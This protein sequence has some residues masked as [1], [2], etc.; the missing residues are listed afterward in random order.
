M[1]MPGPPAPEPAKSNTKVIRIDVVAVV[2]AVVAGVVFFLNKEAPA[3]SQAGDCIHVVDPNPAA[4]KIEKTE[5]TS[6][7]AQY[8]VGMTRDDPNGKCPSQNYLAYS[9]TGGSSEV[10]LCMVLMAK[11]GDCFKP[12]GAVV[13]VKVDCAQGAEFKVSKVIEGSDD[14]KKCGAGENATNAVAYPEPKLTLCRV[15]PDAPGGGA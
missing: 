4:P 5:C 7:D 10:L 11:Q 8:K 12:D 15:A 1:P 13:Y 6:P 2:A 9:E 14:P 3:S